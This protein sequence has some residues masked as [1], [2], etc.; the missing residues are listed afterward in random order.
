MRTENTLNSRSRLLVLIGLLALTVLFNEEVSS[1]FGF[2]LGS[3]AE[4]Q[5]TEL[6]T[7]SVEQLSRVMPEADSFSER[8]SQPPVL[9]AY[10]TDL[11]TGEQTL[12][13]YVFLT[14]DHPREVE[15]FS[16]PIEVLVGMDLQGT[17]TAIKVLHYVESIRKLW[18]DSLA[19]PGYQ[20]QYAGKHI[21]DSFRVGRDI[22]GMT[23]ATITFRAMSRGIRN[24][25]RQV[26]KAYL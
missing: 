20:E 19:T 12:L 13:G 9:E 18:G 24:S 23:R 8:S 26:A 16:A 11:V 7:L 6:S 2:K 25:A 5:A 3:V 15:G 1:L 22:D 14:S 17:L 4:R 21:S 10:H